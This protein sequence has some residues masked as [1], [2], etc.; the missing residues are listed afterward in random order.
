MITD[1]LVGRNLNR[2]AILKI[3][4]Y[5][6]SAS[7]QDLSHIRPRVLAKILQ[8]PADVVID[9]C[10]HGANEGLFDLCW[11]VIC[12]SCRIATTSEDSIVNI[13]KHTHCEACDFDFE[14]NFA[15]NVELIVRV[16]S[17]IRKP[18]T[19]QYCVGG[20]AHSPHV[21]AQTRLSAGETVDLGLELP[22]G[23]YVL[24]GPQLPFFIPVNVDAAS[25]IDRLVVDLSAGWNRKAPAEM[26]VLRQLITVSNH[27]DHEILFRIERSSIPDNAVTALQAAGLPFFRRHFANQIPTAQQLASVQNLTFILVTNRDTNKLVQGVGELASCELRKQHLE[28]LVEL[29]I[30]SE[31]AFVRLV[32]DGGLLVFRSPASALAALEHLAGT[33]PETSDVLFG[34]PVVVILQGPVMVTTINGQ[35]EYL[36]SLLR[37]IH[38]LA[39]IGRPAEITTTIDLGPLLTSAGFEILSSQNQTEPANPEASKS[40]DALSILR[41]RLSGP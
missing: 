22:E 2:T 1:R 21:A 9:V 18:E 8:L 5:V 20:P 26:T 34:P 29:A 37:H 40:G 36:G 23:H 33:I 6:R 24:R 31:G 27:S 14:V 13:K 4:D 3:T 38:S 17:K 41:F 16:N 32:D 35:L 19:G 7:A 28:H 15:S 30:R 11:D 39:A 12:P 25:E 10:L